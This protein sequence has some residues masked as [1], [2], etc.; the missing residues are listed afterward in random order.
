MD[1]L[2]LGPVTCAWRREERRKRE[3][4][5]KEEERREK[6][7]AHQLIFNIGIEQSCNTSRVTSVEW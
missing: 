4:R 6:D 7:T 1:P 3:G 2:T 5:E